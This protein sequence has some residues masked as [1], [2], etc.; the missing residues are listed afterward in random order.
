MR[1]NNV[2]NEDI[3]DFLA[4]VENNTVDL[5]GL[6]LNSKELFSRILIKHIKQS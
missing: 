4:K 6:R 1:L 5:K 3:L 2:Y